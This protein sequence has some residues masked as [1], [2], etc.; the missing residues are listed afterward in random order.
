M[1]PLDDSKIAKD[2]VTDTEMQFYVYKPKQGS[3]L[4]QFDIDWRYIFECI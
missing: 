3:F 1:N 4:D 2:V